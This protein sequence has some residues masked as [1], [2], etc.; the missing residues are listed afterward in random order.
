MDYFKQLKLQADPDLKS[1]EEIINP[2]IDQL[3]FDDWIDCKRKIG[4]KKFN[5]I[6]KRT[7][8]SAIKKKQL[9]LR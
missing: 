5:R 1:I 4:K 7:R 6:D 2:K 3:D 8:R 9:G